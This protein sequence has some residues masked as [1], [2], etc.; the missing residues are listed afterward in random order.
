LSWSSPVDVSVGLAIVSRMLI[1]AL[2]DPRTGL[3][4]VR[5]YRRCVT[6]W[7]ILVYITSRGW[8]VGLVA[9][10]QSA[11]RGAKHAE[12]RDRA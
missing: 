5:D 9:S 10:T 2:S 11:Q 4:W 6:A 12:K 1:E 8:R 3:A 7:L